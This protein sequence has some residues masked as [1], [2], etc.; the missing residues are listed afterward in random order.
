MEN[1]KRDLKFETI[2]DIPFFDSIRGT[3]EHT[4][5]QGNF[6]DYDFELVNVKTGEFMTVELKSDRMTHETDNVAIEMS[7]NGV[8][9]GIMATTSDK[10]VYQILRPDCVEQMWCDTRRL[11]NYV[12]DNLAGRHQYRHKI[13]KGGDGDRSEMM[14]INLNTFKTHIRP[15]T[16]KM[17]RTGE[18]D[19]QLERYHEACR[20]VGV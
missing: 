12:V 20:R 13:A 3:F 2:M 1:F 4:R 10:F 15:K 7:C 16:R 6:K 19:E 18:F 11:F 8:S 9:S 14:L 17:T 5:M